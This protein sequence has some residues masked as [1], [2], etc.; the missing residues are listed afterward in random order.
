M[1]PHTS[2][3][4][5]QFSAIE[6]GQ[7]L[8]VLL[9]DPAIQATFDDLETQAIEAMISAKSAQ[10]RETEALRIQVIRN[11]KTALEH[12]AKSGERAHNEVNHVRT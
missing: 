3:Q 8:S 5:R 10:D 1:K 4:Q 12:K 7:R 9:N 6:I 2:K 11:F